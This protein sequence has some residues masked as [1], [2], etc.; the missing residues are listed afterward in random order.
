MAAKVR[1][2]SCDNLKGLLIFCVVLGHLLEVGS[3]S[4]AD[5]G[6]LRLIYSFH[7]PVFFFIAGRFAKFRGE[8]LVLHWIGTYVIFQILYIFA[9]RWLFHSAAQLQFTTPYWLL[10]FLLVMIFDYALLPLLDRCPKPWVMIPLSLGT[11]LAVG[12]TPSLGYY[13]SLSRFFVF[14]PF[15]LLGRYGCRA[16]A[17]VPLWG[18]LL[19]TGAVVLACIFLCAT[20]VLSLEMLYGSYSYKALAYGA[21]KRLIFYLIAFLWIAFFQWVA[22]PRLNRRIPLLSTLGRNTLPVFLFHGFFVRGLACFWPEIGDYLALQMLLT[23]LLL[24]LFGNPGAARLLPGPYLEKM[25]RKLCKTKKP[26]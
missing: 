16:K 22:L 25:W 6:L 10:W 20:K 21:G 15:F 2:E 17:P 5:E 12:Y 4:P 19:L 14:L 13:L 3:R 7:M 9:A 24:L 23:L 8:K 1:D 11:A 18:K 26:F